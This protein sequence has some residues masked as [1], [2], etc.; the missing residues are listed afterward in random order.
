MRT[1]LRLGLPAAM[2]AG[3][4]SMMSFGHVAAQTAIPVQANCSA[5]GPVA[6]S[7][8][9]GETS[10]QVMDQGQPLY[11]G[12]VVFVQSAVP[13]GS[14]P[15]ECDGVNASDYTTQNFGGPPPSLDAWFSGPTGCAFTV[16]SGTVQLGEL[17]GT[18][19]LA[20]G[21]VPLG[22]SPALTALF[23]ED[24]SCGGLNGYPGTGY[25]S[26]P[27]PY[28][29]EALTPPPPPTTVVIASTSSCS[30]SSCDGDWHHHHHHHHDN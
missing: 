22:G 30:D 29:Y 26:E 28:S 19:V 8:E 4:L 12:S 11:T 6:Y 7:Y 17:V 3:A 5:S 13:Y 23:C 20:N 14:G 18:E 1:V 2:V 21:G 24:S 10:C 16:T 9:S 25:A 15:S 27:Y